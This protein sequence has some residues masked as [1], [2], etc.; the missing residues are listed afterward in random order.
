MVTIFFLVCDLDSP[1]GNWPAKSIVQYLNTR[2]QIASFASN[3]MG[4]PEGGCN[5]EE[6]QEHRVI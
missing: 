6:M 3:Q 1:F 4:K 2:Q 5:N